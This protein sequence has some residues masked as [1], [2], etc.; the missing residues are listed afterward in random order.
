MR[1]HLLRSIIVTRFL[2]ERSTHHELRSTL[3]FADLTMSEHAKDIIP[4][5]NGT[6]SVIHRVT[7]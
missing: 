7:A 5:T 3:H 1:E 6:I 2:P 4:E